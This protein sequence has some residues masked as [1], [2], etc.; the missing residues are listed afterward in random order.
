MK[1]SDLPKNADVGDSYSID[2][3][4]VTWN[5]YEWVHLYKVYPEN[6]TQDRLNLPYADH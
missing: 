6:H 5:G 2:G 4:Q 1:I 3:M